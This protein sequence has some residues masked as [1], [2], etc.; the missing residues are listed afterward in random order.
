MRSA[1]IALLAIA[2]VLPSSAPGRAGEGAGVTLAEPFT[3]HMVL[4]RGR[5]VPVWGWAD[6]GEEVTVA[7]NGQ[8]KAVTAGED[9]RWRIDLEPMEAGGPYEMRIKGVEK[10]LREV[11][12]GDVWLCSGQS[13]ME[14]GLDKMNGAPPFRTFH[15][16]EDLARANQ[17]HLRLFCAPKQFV[18]DP[19][20][21]YPEPDPKSD[22]IHGRWVPCTIENAMACGHWGGFSGLAFYFG[23]EI[24]PRADVTIGLVQ[25]ASGGTAAEAW[26]SPEAAAS[27]KHPAACPTFAEAKKR[28]PGK[29]QRGRRFDSISTCYNSQVHPLVPFAFRGVL[30]NQG[31]SNS[32]D[33]HYDQKLATL[34]RDWRERFEYPHMPF[35]I[36]QLC[37]FKNYLGNPTARPAVRD[38][39]LKTHQRVPQTGL[40]VTLDLFDW[41][42]PND[43]HPPDKKEV[44]RRLALWARR[45]CYGEADLEPSG[46]IFR[47]M[48]LEKNKARLFFDHLGGGLV[49]PSHRLQGF[50]IAGAERR[51]HPARAEIDGDTVI[52]WS[53]DVDEPRYVRYGWDVFAFCTLYNRAGLPASPFRTDDW[54]AGVY[55]DESDAR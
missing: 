48:K 4:Q 47:E 51:F 31:G 37:S 27:L 22:R 9:G 30:W 11:M 21:R 20:E 35:Y 17:P 44:A 26:M 16:P 1:T 43:V 34:I 18:A 29:R 53:N 33:W 39:Q 3:D 36:V 13:N 5:R 38:G 28:F 8:T 46:P 7:F 52:V 15:A 42:E 12:V 2:I 14:M 24:Q 50:T 25:A 23:L 49:C 19:Q 32:G 10:P 41:H 54:E 55:H 45:D 40:T 6:P